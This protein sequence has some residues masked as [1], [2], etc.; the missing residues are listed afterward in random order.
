MKLEALAAGGAWVEG[1]GDFFEIVAG[2]PLRIELSPLVRELVLRQQRKGKPADLAAFFH[3]QFAA[4]WAQAVKMAALDTGLNAVALSG[5]VFCNEIL[6]KELIRRL[7]LLGLTVLR[8][9]R[10]PPNDGC[11][12]LGQAAVASARG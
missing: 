1:E 6:T 11:I 12:A 3:R 8:H 5:G 7:D 9:R 4:A 2:Q 10:F